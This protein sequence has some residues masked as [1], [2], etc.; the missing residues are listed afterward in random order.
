MLTKT[1][2]CIFCLPPAKRNPRGLW[3]PLLGIGWVTGRL[4]LALNWT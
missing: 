2:E 4:I 1:A 3:S